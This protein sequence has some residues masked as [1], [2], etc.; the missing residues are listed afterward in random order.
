MAG[1]RACQGQLAAGDRLAEDS[2]VRF[3][4]L[5]NQ[6]LSSPTPT[7]MHALGKVFGY[8][9]RGKE[10]IKKARNVCISHM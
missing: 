2:S 7:T 1:V 5:T 8:K 6:P 10:R 3:L 4:L 9:C